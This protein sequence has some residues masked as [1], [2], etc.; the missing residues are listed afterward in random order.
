LD[1]IDETEGA[2]CVVVGVAVSC[3]QKLRQNNETTKQHNNSSQ[4]LIIAAISA[5]VP[6]Q[7]LV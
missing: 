1:D 2:S 3:V 7:G 5:L 4:P 6:H